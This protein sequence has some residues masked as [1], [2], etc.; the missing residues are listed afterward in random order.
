[1]R[2]ATATGLDRVKTREWNSR[3]LLGVWRAAWADAFNHALERDGKRVRIDHRTLEAQ[4]E[5]ARE[6]GDLVGSM[7]LDRR[8]EIHVGTRARQI[9]YNGRVPVS[10]TRE[11]E[12]FRVT[13]ANAP[14]RRRR[15][16]YP[17]DR[18]ARL[19]WMESII[20][21]NSH[22]LKRSLIDIE[23]KLDRFNR[24]LDYKVR[25]EALERARYPQ[26]RKSTSRSEKRCDG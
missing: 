25:R 16:D 19:L 10:R 26:H 8:P 23:R 12:P 22:D 7:M 15:R 5:R 21:R 18:G 9:L 2:R 3:D 4:R 13:V 6:A 17:Q 11:T 20:A 24:R 14:P 1:M